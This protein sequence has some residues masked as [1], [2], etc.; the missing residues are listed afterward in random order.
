MGLSRQAYYQG[1]RRHARRESRAEAV[2]QLVRDWRVRQ[3]RLGTRKLHHV[4]RLNYRPWCQPNLGRVRAFATF[5][6]HF[7]FLVLIFTLK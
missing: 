1:Q 6:W 2:V 3:P 5:G 7:F 4:L